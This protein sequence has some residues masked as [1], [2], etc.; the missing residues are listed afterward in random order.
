MKAAF[1]QVLICLFVATGDFK[2][3]QLKHPRVKEAYDQ[4]EQSLR[5]LYKEKGV[6]FLA[7]PVFLRV[8]KEEKELELW[9]KP[10]KSN[11]VLVKTYTICSTSGIPGPK[12]RRGDGQIPEGFYHIDHFNPYSSFHLSLRLNYPN[13]SDRIISKAAD[14]GGNIFIHGN[15]ISIGCMAMT[16]DK[17]KELYIAS[18]EAKNSGQNTIPVHIFPFRM[19][20][21]NMHHF[22]EVYQDYPSM[23]NFWQNL[24]IGYD[25]Y[26]KVHKL[27]IVTVEPNG[28][29]KFQ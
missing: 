12:R 7:S 8:F 20:S 15:C 27:P 9:V 1:L 14:L 16:D 10:A 11:F 24:K 6:D 3:G 5:L 2:S 17:I 18:V 21:E 25:Y 13:A 4:K 22:S 19:N 23:I 26:E 28:L 29:Y